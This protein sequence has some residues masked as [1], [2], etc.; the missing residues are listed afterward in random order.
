[1]GLGLYSA[2]MASLVG[3]IGVDESGKGDYFGP[4]VIAA[5]FV[6]PWHEEFLE[7]VMD[8]KKLTDKKA[9]ALSGVIKEHCPHSVIAVGP[10]RY[11]EMH[12]KMKNLNRMLEW[13]HAKAIENVLSL[14]GVET[15]EVISDQFANPAGL[16]RVLGLKGLDVDLE[17]RVRAES[18]LAV[19]AA[20]V[21]ARAEFLRKLEKLGDEVGVPLMKGAGPGVDQLARN[22]VRQQGES[23]LARVAK[24]HFKTTEKV[25]GRAWG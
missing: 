16:K 12:A 9:L 14:E 10:E 23:V 21:L 24:V 22:L 15:R 8:S 2:P 1:M 11:N 25:L 20:S 7:G 17:S 4:L 19:A 18:D 5:C 3:R 13:G 6:A